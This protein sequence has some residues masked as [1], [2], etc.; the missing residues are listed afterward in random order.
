MI[1]GIVLVST[2]VMAGGAK[3]A[4]VLY[5]EPLHALC[6]CFLLIAKIPLRILGLLFGLVKNLLTVVKRTARNGAALCARREY[7]GLGGIPREDLLFLTRDGEALLD[8]NRIPTE[9]LEGL[10]FLTV[11]GLC[12]VLC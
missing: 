7:R 12:L 1:R 2:P 3:L 5:V 6:L 10:A 8:N 11:V 4:H 9:K